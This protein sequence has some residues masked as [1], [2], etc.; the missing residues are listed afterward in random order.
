SLPPDAMTATALI[1]SGAPQGARPFERFLLTAEAWAD[2]PA[3]LTA[4]PAL[5]L[6][7][8]WAEPGMVHAAFLE[9]EAGTVL[10]ASAPAE[11]GRYAALS[12]ARPGAIRFERLIRDL[13][14][15]TAE[16]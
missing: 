16:G 7:G 4:E 9:E 3:A 8:M 14:A 12:P 15:L 5:A 6:L 11:S 2:L 13:W 1:R 10:L